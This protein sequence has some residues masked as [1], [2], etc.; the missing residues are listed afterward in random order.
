MQKL[1]NAPGR[2]RIKRELEAG[3]EVEEMAKKTPPENYAREK[4]RRQSELNF[5]GFPQVFQASIPVT[6]KKAQAHTHTHTEKE[7]KRQER[8]LDKGG[9]K[10]LKKLEIVKNC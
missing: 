5:V 10:R 4:E 6:R 2:I 8:K 3:K 9:K 7:R 1:F